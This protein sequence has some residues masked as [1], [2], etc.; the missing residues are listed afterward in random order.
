MA[1]VKDSL[2]SKEVTK[3]AEIKDRRLAVRGR[4]EKSKNKKTRK[5]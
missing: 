1:D 5:I 3:K 2:S 4:S